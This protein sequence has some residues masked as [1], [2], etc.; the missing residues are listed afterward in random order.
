MQQKCDRKIGR[1]E[2]VCVC[3][4]ASVAY[5]VRFDIPTAATGQTAVFGLCDAV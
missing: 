1:N 2:A 5:R 4:C 3:R